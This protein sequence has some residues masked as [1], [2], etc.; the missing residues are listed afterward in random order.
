MA[1]MNRDQIE[2]K[3]LKVTLV[4]MAIVIILTI[5]LLIGRLY[6]GIT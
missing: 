3:F 1:Q 5:L 4:V 2:D 6:L